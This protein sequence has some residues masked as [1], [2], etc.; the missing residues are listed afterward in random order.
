MNNKIKIGVCFHKEEPIHPY[1]S[2]KNVFL[3]IHAR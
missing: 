2:D 3:P 1:I